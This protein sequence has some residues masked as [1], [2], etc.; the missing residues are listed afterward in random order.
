VKADYIDQLE[1][2]LLAITPADASG[3][4]LAIIAKLLLFIV[5]SKL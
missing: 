1:E 2:A 3:K 5:R 4:L